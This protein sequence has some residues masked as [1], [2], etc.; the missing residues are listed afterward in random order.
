MLVLVVLPLSSLIPSQAL[1]LL[2]L[3][4]REALETFDSCGMRTGNEAS[5]DSCG[6]RTGNEASFHS[7]TSSG[8]LSMYNLS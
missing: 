2:L 8:N 4:V 5:D 3:A 7:L 1:Q 6:M